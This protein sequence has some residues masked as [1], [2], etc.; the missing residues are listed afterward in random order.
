VELTRISQCLDTFVR[1]ATSPLAIKMIGSAEE[2]PERAKMPKRDLGITVPLCQGLALSRRHGMVVAMSEE[3]ML[4][5]VGAVA[6]GLLPAK[7][8]FL[9]GSFRIPFWVPTQ[10]MTGNL[11]RGMARLETGRYTYVVAAP[12][13]R[14]AFEPDVIV[15]YGNP[16]Q[17]A[18]L[19]QATVYVTGEPVVSRSAGSFSCAE[20]ISRTM[21]TGRCQYVIAGGGD[22]MIAQAQDD[23]ASFALPL[24]QADALAEGL[25]E[26]H[27]RGVRYPTRS[28]LTFSAAMPKSFNQMTEY[29]QGDDE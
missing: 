9:D 12:I 7:P 28:Y 29:L 6:L 20:Q 11:A 21:L 19:I 10:E 2:I 22:R 4:C 18:R 25:E 23:E 17:I 15:V 16:A 27:K 13:E 5:P 3:D 14:A 8:K 26:S 1:P 24:S